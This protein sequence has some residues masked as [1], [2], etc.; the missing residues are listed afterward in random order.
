MFIPVVAVAINHHLTMVGHF[1]QLRYSPTLRFVVFGAISYTAVSFQGS[2]EALRTQS[3]ITHF[4]HYTIGHAHLGLYAFVTMILFGSIYY[5]MPRIIKWEWPYPSL[6]KVHFWLVAAGIILYVI[7]M[8]IG[9]VVQGLYMNDA[10][11]PFIDSVNVTKPYLIAR[12]AGG[13]LMLLG[14]LVFI[15]LFCLMLFRKGAYRIIPPWSERTAEE[16]SK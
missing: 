13:S 9:G 5:I 2:L 3:E 14:Q 8:N 15:Y 10:S 1:G 11:R 16:A 4:T 12:S 7:S 6:I